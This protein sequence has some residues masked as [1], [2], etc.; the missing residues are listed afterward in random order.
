MPSMPESIMRFT[1][2][3]PPPP[4]PM[5]LILASLRASSLKLMRMSFS[6][7]MVYCTSMDFRSALPKPLTTKDTEVHKGFFDQ[8]FLCVSLYPL[9]VQYFYAPFFANNPIRREL[10]RVSCRPRAI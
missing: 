2:L 9:L 1:A 8:T 10:Q 3:P 6:F 4:T 7:F 5:T